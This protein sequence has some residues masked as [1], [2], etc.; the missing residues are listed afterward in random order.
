MMLQEGEKS[1]GGESVEGMGGPTVEPC[2]L[3]MT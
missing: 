3:G 1:E 2:L